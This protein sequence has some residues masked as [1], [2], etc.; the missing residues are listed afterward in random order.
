MATKIGLEF[1]DFKGIPLFLS[2]IGNP[3]IPDK[4][5]VIT[6][7]ITLIM[8]PLFY[9]VFTANAVNSH[10]MKGLLWI[11]PIAIF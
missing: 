10:G 5:V 1:P 8:E 11:S 9:L 3:S 2:V 6:G 4:P 7:V